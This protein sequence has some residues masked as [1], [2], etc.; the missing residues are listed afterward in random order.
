MK[1]LVLGGD[2]FCGWPTSLHLAAEGYAVTIADNLSRRAIADDLGAPSLTPIRS[3]ED[4]VT[5]ARNVGDVQFSHL[6][7][8]DPVA[9][10]ALLGT[11]E[12]D[13]IVH[14]AEQRS[15]PYSMLGDAQRRYTVANNVNGTNTLFSA[16]VELGQRPHV[17]HL[18]TMGVY[19]YSDDLG[20]LQE[21]YLD[22][23]VAQ[24]GRD[25]TIGYPA[26]PGSI[27]HLTKCLDHTLMQ[28]YA[29]N[30][31]FQITDLHQGIVWGTD[32]EITSSDEALINRFDYDGEYGTVLN[33]L[34]SQAAVGHP[35]TVYGT[36]GQ[37]RAFIHISDTARCVHLATGA[38]PD[39]GAQVQV[40]NQVAEV[41]NV[42][43]LARMIAERTGAE[44]SY[45]DNP[46]KEAAAN[47]L[48]VSNAGLRSLGFEPRTL[49]DSL[50][51]EISA[52]VGRYK[53]RLNRDVI[54]SKARW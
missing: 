34:V 5:A 27:Y 22:V 43:A 12:P 2:G 13:V 46:R 33:R 1:A 30:W 25:V 29:K 14:F 15:A 20:E 50:M 38:P 4:R 3:I 44:V 52:T 6:D 21:G 35:L 8:T 23:R 51:D 41:R 9:L 24:T 11:L 7:V 53:D 19:G 10:K 32:S 28:F 48:R 47:Q 31:Q 26:N 17:V 54:F 37:S 36:G 49:E 16:L 45:L 18:G 42:G 39:P 40:F